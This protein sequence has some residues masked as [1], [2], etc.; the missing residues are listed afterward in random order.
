M[1]RLVNRAVEKWGSRD[2]RNVESAWVAWEHSV[3]ATR[4]HT[5]DREKIA[6]QFYRL[7]QHLG[8]AREMVFPPIE[9]VHRVR[10]TAGEIIRA[11]SAA[12]DGLHFETSE[13]IV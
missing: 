10:Y 4:Q 11:Q 2:H 3:E 13:E 8:A 12:D 6:V 5:Y 7:S 9:G 1:E